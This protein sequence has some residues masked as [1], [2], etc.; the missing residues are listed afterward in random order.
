M[1]QLGTVSANE[2]RAKVIELDTHSFD[3]IVD[4]NK[5]VF[6]QMGTSWCSHCRA[7]SDAW[8]HLA[9]SYSHL[10]PDSDI[11]IAKID[12]EKNPD[13]ARRFGITAYP[14]LKLFTKGSKPPATPE[15]A[16]HIGGGGGGS[17]GGVGGIESFEKRERDV[18]TLANFVRDKTGLIARIKRARSYVVKVSPDAFGDIVLDPSKHVFVA[19]KADFCTFCKKMAPTWEKLAK[20]FMAEDDVVIASVDGSVAKEIVRKYKVDGFP[21]MLLFGKGSGEPVVYEGPRSEAEMVEFLNKHAGKSR[22][23]GGGL[24]PDAGTIGE[25]D[26]VVAKFA[27]PDANLTESSKAFEEAKQIVAASIKAAKKG[28]ANSRHNKYAKYYLKVMENIMNGKVAFPENETARLTK[29]CAKGNIT[30]H[31]LDE[32]TIRRNILMR[33]ISADASKAAALIEQMNSHHQE[34]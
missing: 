30:P 1:M 7:M 6:V 18:D 33:F 21:T 24:G 27:A 12:A 10:S 8:T 28:N 3:K 11:V 17:G 32:F 16:S 20:T 2:E 34:L 13:I 19:F 15:E 23:A 5:H 25:L 29:I 26:A 31:K 4:G 22:L 14:Q 9:D